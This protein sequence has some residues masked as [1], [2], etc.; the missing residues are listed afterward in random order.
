MCMEILA[1]VCSAAGHKIFIKIWRIFFLPVYT[2]EKL[3]PVTR[4]GRRQSATG[5]NR[6]EGERGRGGVCE[7]V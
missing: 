4:V 7:S 5:H 6:K 3:L 2:P 1:I